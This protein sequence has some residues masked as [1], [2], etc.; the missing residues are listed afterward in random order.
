MM[1]ATKINW[2][3]AAKAYAK[4]AHQNMF[5]SRHGYFWI[6]GKQGELLAL[7]YFN[8][9]PLEDGSREQG[10]ARFRA[11]M[12]QQADVSEL[13]VGVFPADGYTIAMLLKAAED[14]LDAIVEQLQAVLTGEAAADDN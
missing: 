8:N 6:E 12:E 7:C 14:K 5:S 2:K 10:L 11:W 3:S 9:N 13:A 4:D 1:M